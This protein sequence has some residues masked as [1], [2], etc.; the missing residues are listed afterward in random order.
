MNRTGSL[1]T[2]SLVVLSLA[3]CVTA[4][5]LSPDRSLPPEVEETLQDLARHPGGA[6]YLEDAYSYAVFPTILRGAFG[7]GWGTG[8]GVLVEQ[9]EVVGHVEVSEFIHGIAFGGG[10]YSEVIL[11]RDATALEA[12]KAGTLEFRGRAGLSAGTLGAS[13]SPAFADGVAIITMTEAGAM[14][15]FSVS[16]AGYKFLPSDMPRD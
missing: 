7:W 15:D 5:R 4:P 13:T 3:G 12:F 8:K 16:G 11:F 2:V 14:V 6:A 1:L 9:G 10:Y